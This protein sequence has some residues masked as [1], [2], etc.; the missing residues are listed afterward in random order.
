MAFRWDEGLHF[1][2]GLF[3]GQEEEAPWVGVSLG[4]GGGEEVVVDLDTEFC[5]EIKQ[6]EGLGWLDEERRGGD[7]LLSF[8]DGLV[9]ICRSLT[10]SWVRLSCLW[11]SM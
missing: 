11:F 10:G 4:V 1:V 6:A 9:W 5:W 3:A 8:V 2:V 7:T